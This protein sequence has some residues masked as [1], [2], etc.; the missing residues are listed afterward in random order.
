MFMYKYMGNKGVKCDQN[1][2]FIQI[3]EYKY[4]YVQKSTSTDY[5]HVHY[6]K[7]MFVLGN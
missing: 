3:F 1:I 5:I 7:Y 6:L 2:W 4:M